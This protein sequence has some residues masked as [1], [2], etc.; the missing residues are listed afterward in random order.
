MLVCIQS[1]QLH[2]AEFLLKARREVIS[3]KH[4]LVATVINIINGGMI[5]L[6]WRHETILCAIHYGRLKTFPVGNG[7]TA[8]SEFVGRELVQAYVETQLA[9]RSD[10][11]TEFY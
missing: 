8:V 3:E 9:H 6:V 10:I 4:S 5:A 11:G 2:T 1:L 7:L